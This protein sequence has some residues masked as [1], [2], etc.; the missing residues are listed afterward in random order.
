M[1]EKDNSIFPLDWLK[2][3][4][5][6]WRRVQNMLEKKD[7]EAAGFFLQQSLEKYL[8]GFLLRQGWKLKKIHELDALLDDAVKY[9]PNLKVFYELCDRVAGYYFADRYPPFVAEEIACEDIEKDMEEAKKFVMTMFPEE[10][11]R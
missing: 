6:D 1:N 11:I 8:K 7:A 10:E 3:A 9:N 4:R 5:K 2:I